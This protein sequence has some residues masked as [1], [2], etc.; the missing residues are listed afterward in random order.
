M[1]TD[2]SQFLGR[3][4]PLVVHLPI[5]IIVFAVLLVIISAYRKSIL[6]DKAIDIALLA[7][8][9]GA[10]FAIVT[11]F[12]LSGKGGYD[13][14]TLSWHKWIGI[15]A[16]IVCFACWLT[17]RKPEP[18]KKTSNALLIISTILIAIGGHLGGNMTHGEGYLTKYLPASLQKI[19]GAAPKT[20]PK[21]TF[22]SVD[23]VI[24]Y[25]DI[26][27]PVLN[28]K[29]IS[30]HNPGKQKGDLDLSS[31][32]GITKGG[33]SGA[34]VIAADL[35]KSELLHRVTLPV[36]S[37]KFMPA[38]NQPAL[39]PVEI[40]LIKWWINTGAD[41]EKNVAKQHADDKSKYLISA[42]LGIDA[43]N[44]KD[45]IL[46]VAAAADSAALK[47]LKEAGIILR[48]V[49]SESNLLQ[50]SF[51]MVQQSTES[52]IVNLLN[53]LY[54]VKEQ[55]YQLDVKH[56][57]LSKEALQIIG[58]F[59]MLNKLDMQQTKLADEIITPLGKLQQLNILNIGENDI[60]DKSFAV[61]K[62]MKALKKTNLWQTKV[63]EDGIK[64]FQSVSKDITI[65]H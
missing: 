48:S 28:N 27:Q 29:C 26:I 1:Q 61:L 58:S 62:E 57:V 36:T 5:G 52:E 56:C 39:T 2:W 31:K 46:P 25:E 40:S 34:A 8:F 47:Q 11:G 43:A 18:G 38:D 3:F 7:G 21:K 42:Y 15:A 6:L 4:H 20:I 53:K 51:V 35:E 22:A 44:D 60:T 10:V 14:N 19:F 16:A 50:A 32:D 49:S 12:L 30:C 54:A 37:S 9:A 24:V 17:R 64:D 45:I 65:E 59:S 33:K 63:T 23:S 13:A 55:L 41:Y